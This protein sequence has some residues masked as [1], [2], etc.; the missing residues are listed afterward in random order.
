MEDAMSENE[1][2]EAETREQWLERVSMLPGV[3]VH[4]NP[5][6][7]PWVPPDDV[8]VNPGVTVKDILGYD[9]R[10]VS[11]ER[12]DAGR[13]LRKSF[14]RVESLKRAHGHSRRRSKE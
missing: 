10:D 12:E 13:A 5:N 4:H 9:H 6:P 1:P 2:P 14:G 7:V 8:R 3:I 11:P